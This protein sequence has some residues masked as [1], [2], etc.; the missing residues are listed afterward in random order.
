MSPSKKQFPSPSRRGELRGEVD[1]N[2]EEILVI[3]GRE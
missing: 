3:Y 1:M 2:K